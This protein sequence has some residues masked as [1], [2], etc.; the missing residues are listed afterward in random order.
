MILV[1]DGSTDNCPDI[2]DEWAKKDQR[3][4]VIHKVNGGLSDA[5]NAGINVALGDYL[6]FV[7][8]DD[9]IAEHTYA[10]LM[11]KLAAEPDIDI[12]EY[13]VFVHYGSSQ[14]HLLD[15]AEEAEY[16]NMDD[17]W[18]SGKAYQHSY[19]CNKIYRTSLF[20]DVRYPVGV[21]FEDI[22]T[23]PLLLR[24]TQKVATCRQ[25]LYY[26]CSNKTGITATANGDALRMLLKPHVDIIRNSHRQDR[27]AQLYYLHVLNI[28]MDVFEQTGDTP[29]LPIRPI[30]TNYF[31]SVLKLKAI[32]LNLLGVRKLCMLNKLIHRIWR[33]H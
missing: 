33:N 21:V 32:A 12:L 20:A 7:D 15:F 23:L 4:K 16:I 13:P 2:C 8:S 18:Y 29:I 30:N 17:Y 31:S 26:Y 5:R 24:K 3:I 28:Q 27:E 11:Q 9:Y 22:H 1:D 19:A 25:G 10:P 6:T 14:Q